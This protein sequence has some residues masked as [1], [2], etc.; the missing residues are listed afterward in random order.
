MQLV[1]PRL[2]LREYR[3]T[4][5]EAVHRFASDPEATTFVT[6]GPN[7]EDETRGFIEGWLAERAAGC[8]GSGRPADPR[9][10]GPAAS[11]RRSG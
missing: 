6:W 3:Q 7:T 9:T 1:T 8:A 11:W 5:F 4:D 10:W 2:V